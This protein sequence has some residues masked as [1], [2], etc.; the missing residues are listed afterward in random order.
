MQAAIGGCTL[1][2]LQLL[3]PPGLPMAARERFLR[4][5]LVFV[6]GGRHCMPVPSHR[7]L[8]LRIPCC[9]AK[10]KLDLGREKGKKPAIFPQSAIAA[11]FVAAK[12]F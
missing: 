8:R 2:A 1:T 6:R 7:F 11:A 3:M 10:E 4:A 9:R 12:I 5:R